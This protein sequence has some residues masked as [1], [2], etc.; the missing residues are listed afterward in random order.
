M[1]APAAG[2]PEPEEHNPYYARYISL[3]PEGDVVAT[4][5][6]QLDGT[7]A[8]LR[9]LSETQAGARYAPDKW[10][11]REVVGHVIDTE[12]IFGYRA[13][14]FARGDGTPLPGFEQDDYV[15]SAAFDDYPLNELADELEHVR[16][17]NLSFFRHLDGVAWLRRGAAN[18]S[19]VS[20]RALAYIM[21]GHELHHVGVL[22]AK[23]L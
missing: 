8:L 11:V 6:R 14:R 18:D 2:R 10:S 4:L 21:A 17:S 20:V 22:R 12:R 16:R 15:R 19:E 13:L 9:G 5:E 23:Y 3:V 1:S 7:L